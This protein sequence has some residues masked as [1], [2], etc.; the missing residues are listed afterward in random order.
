M[1]SKLLMINQQRRYLVQLTEYLVDD[2]SYNYCKIVT[3]I[4]AP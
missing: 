4:H 2:I 1:E 3:L